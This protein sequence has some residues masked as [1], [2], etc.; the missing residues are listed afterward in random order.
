MLKSYGKTV[1]IL[2]ATGNTG[3]YAVQHALNAQDDVHVFVR[4]PA[5]LSA[6][7]KDQIHV[8]VGNLTE[9]SAMMDAVVKVSPTAIIIC[10]GHPPKDPIGPLNSTAVAAI[11]KA[12]I[13]TQRLEDCFV[14]YL[15]GLFSDPFYDP[16][17]WYTRFLRAVLL[18]MCGYQAL[19]RDN[20]EVTKY[21]TAGEGLKRGLRFTIVRMGYPINAPSK[22]AIIPVDYYPL[23][24]VT[25]NDIGLFLVK[26]AHGEHRDAVLGKAIKPFYTRN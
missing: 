21:L 13:E 12:L 16:L 4:D 24:A 9:S 8:I 7:I 15:S 5:K 20:L 23:G 26:L 25:F 14:V 19:L 10:S 3:K 2:G 22:G 11:V 6:V 17:P 18:P 1:L